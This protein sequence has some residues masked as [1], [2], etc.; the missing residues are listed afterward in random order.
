MRFLF[1]ALIVTIGLSGCA[2][3]ESESE[4]PEQ[5]DG[6]QNEMPVSRSTS[7][8]ENT[9]Q[10]V[11]K[12]MKNQ[13]EAALDEYIDIE[14]GL[15]FVESTQGAYS[16][17][18]NYESSAK[19]FLYSS[20]ASEYEVNPLKYLLDYF[21]NV[22]MAEFEI[23]EE[24]LF[25]REACNFQE[26]GFFL[27]SN[28]ADVKMLTDI[29]QMNAERDGLDI[30]PNELLKLGDTQNAVIKT[31]FIGDGEVTYTFYFTEKNNKWTLTIMDMR[32]CDT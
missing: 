12:A 8:F 11:I 7:T 25:G 17:C 20:E 10:A 32:D 9:L 5:T 4:Q 6:L 29:Y 27:D 3:T 31:V 24:D 18:L 2:S 19:L 14:N 22:D 15:F 26:K 23:V 13:D 1:F 30:E 28:E 16:E 21:N